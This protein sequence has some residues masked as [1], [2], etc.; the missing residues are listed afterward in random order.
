MKVLFIFLILF[1]L[2]TS[3]ISFADSILI[4]K[5]IRN[6][7]SLKKNNYNHLLFNFNL[8]YSKNMKDLISL[9]NQEKDARKYINDNFGNRYSLLAKSRLETDFNDIQFGYIYNLGTVLEINNPIFPEVNSYL[10]ETKSFYTRMNTIKSNTLNQE[11]IIYIG[12]R[13]L[14]E[15]NIS[16]EDFLITNEEDFFNTDM[17]EK[18][19][20]DLS[21]LNSYR[22]DNMQFHIDFESIPIYNKDINYWRILK[23]FSIIA[24]NS[25][26]FNYYFSILNAEKD[27]LMN[28]QK[29]GF[30]YNIDWLRTSLYFNNHNPEIDLSLKYWFFNIYMNYK[31]EKLYESPVINEKINY[32]LNFYW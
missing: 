13:K 24:N 8:S 16:F 27:S 4:K 18:G 28:H 25:L 23:G 3:D 14:K 6:S 15:F 29:I 10:F 1:N 22:Y 21:L 17:D 9:F 19:F 26:S 11:A 12:T 20:I 30:E 31:K 5:Q 2:I 7:L 32:G